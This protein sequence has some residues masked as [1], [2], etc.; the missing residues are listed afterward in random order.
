ML[1]TPDP[2][3]PWVILCTHGTISHAFRSYTS[4]ADAETDLNRL[5]R[6]LGGYTLEICWNG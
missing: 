5:S 2:E 3:K 1:P 6:I 4:R